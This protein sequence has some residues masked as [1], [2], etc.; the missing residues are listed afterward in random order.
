M[1][2]LGDML[3]IGQMG[4]GEP[5]LWQHFGRGTADPLA[6]GTKL[7]GASSDFKYSASL[8]PPQGSY[9]IARSIFSA[10]C[11]NN[12][13]ISLGSDFNSDTDPEMDYGFMMLVNDTF[14]ASPK[15]VYVD[16]IFQPLCPGTDY[17][18]SAAIINLVK[19]EI[20]TGLKSFPNISFQIEDESGKVLF[21]DT[22]GPI[23]FADKTFGYK[24]GVFGVSFKMP[25]GYKRL[26]A[27]IKVI[28]SADECGSDFAVD[29]IRVAAAGPKADISF[30]NEFLSTILKSVCFQQNKTI[31]LTGEVEPFYAMQ[32][33]QWQQ[34]TD[35]GANWSDIPGANDKVYSRDF[36]IPDTFLFRL[37]VA[38]AGKIANKYCRIVSDLLTVQ[39]NGIPSNLKVETNAPVCAGQQLTFLAS[40][41][42]TYEWYGP[43][44]F[45]DNIPFPH[46][47]KSALKD[48]GMYYTDIFTLGGCK[49]RDSVYVKIIGTDVSAG[50]DTA[51]CLGKPVTL[52]A[53]KGLVYRWTSSPGGNLWQTQQITVL[54]LQNTTYTLSVTDK[55]GCTDSASVSIKLRNHSLLQAGMLAGEYVCYGLDSMLFTSTS[56]GDIEKWNW[57]FDNGNFSQEEKPPVQYY[58]AGAGDVSYTIIL[59]VSDSAGCTDSLSHK[60]KVAPNCYIAVPTGFTPNGD[61]L[62]DFLYPLNAFKATHLTFRVYS[63]DGLLLFETHDWNR[64]WDGNLNGIQQPSGAYAWM[65]NYVDAAGKAVL[66]KGTTMLIR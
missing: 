56:K 55:E 6:L 5:V 20:C 19:P 13:W 25:D 21:A 2:V 39:V 60:L 43:N 8:C 4:A 42:A 24:F 16:T 62:N 66:L 1:I 64:K 49:A 32:A 46:I 17:K 61:G 37:S 29:D 11:A 36:S 34:S 50:N 28:S 40:G 12:S 51:I 53:S 15:M 23:G 10:G 44:G 9:S 18:F 33:L 54:P 47:Y 30:S 52:Q 41:G 14:H 27:K 22:T 59:H 7:P 31:E 58:Y 45:Y 63:R 38:E 35:D 3:A 65:L 26:V 57:N 48:S